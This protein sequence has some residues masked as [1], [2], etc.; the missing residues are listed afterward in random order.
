MAAKP[1]KAKILASK[2]K[3]APK[4]KPK[5]KAYVPVAGAVARLTGKGGESFLGSF[6]KGGEVLRHFV[7]GGCYITEPASGSRSDYTAKQAS[8]ADL[9][10]LR[11]Q[12]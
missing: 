4:A 11:Q 8:E 12:E 10:S 3:A 7:R 9:R 1:T 2:S 5:A 6:E